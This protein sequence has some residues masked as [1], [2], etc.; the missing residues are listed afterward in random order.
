MTRDPLEMVDGPNVYAYV[1][2]RPV[3]FI[4]LLGKELT[5]ISSSKWVKKC[6]R[7]LNEC[8]DDEKVKG[9]LDRAGDRI[10]YDD[11]LDA[12]GITAYDGWS[13][14]PNAIHLGGVQ[15]VLPTSDG[16]ILGDDK[17]FKYFCSTLAHEAVHLEQ[18]FPTG[19]GAEK[20]AQDRGQ[21][22][23]DNAWGN[24]KFRKKIMSN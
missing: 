12:A 15:G 22:A 23:I 24:E 10:S 4:D 18:W 21:G 8:Q 16:K 2:C 13:L 17:L 7:L 9:G 3:L 20:E 5:D 11:Q 6:K 19:E 14:F 1:A